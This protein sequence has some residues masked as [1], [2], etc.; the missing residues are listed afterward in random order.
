[1]RLEDTDWNVRCFA[2]RA[3]AAVA[4]KGDMQTISALCVRLEDLDSGVR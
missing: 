2:V 4:K 3:L 1:M